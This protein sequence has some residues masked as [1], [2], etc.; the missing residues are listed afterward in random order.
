MILYWDASCH[1][2]SA[3]NGAEL[4]APW[5]ALTVRGFDEEYRLGFVPAVAEAER[6]DSNC[7]PSWY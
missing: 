5:P 4:E 7:E 6:I 2:S 3:S 1:A